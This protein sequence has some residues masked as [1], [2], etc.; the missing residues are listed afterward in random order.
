MT[1]T[2]DSFDSGKNATPSPS[3]KPAA[4]EVVRP[5]FHPN[6]RWVCGYQPVGMGCVEGPTEEG[7]CCQN[8]HQ[9]ASREASCDS[10]CGCAAH[11]ELAALRNNPGLPSHLELGP[12]VPRRS[13]WFTRQTIGLN[14]AILTGG[15]L[16]LCMA[17]PVREQVFVPGGLS[18]KHS[19]ILGN[20]LVSQRCSLCHAN[21]HSGGEVIAQD[22]LCMN[23]HQSHMPDAVLRSPHD[24]NAEQLSAIRW[25]PATQLVSTQSETSENPLEQTRCASCHKEH[26]GENHQLDF[27][28]DTRCQ[29]CHAQKFASLA[30][31]HPEFENFPQPARRSI[32]F[33][34]Q[35]HA[36]QHF[37]KKD[38][39]FDCRAC[40]LVSV[41][42]NSVGVVLR[43]QAFEVAC[44]SCHADRLKSAGVGGWAL[45]QVPSLEA[46]DVSDSANDFGNWP[47]G[48]QFGY[49]GTVPLV[50]RLLLSSDENAGEALAQL[51]TDGALG[52][53]DP[54]IQAEA[55]RALALATRALIA[56]VALHG[57]AA[58]RERLETVAT[59]KLGRQLDEDELRLVDQLSAGLPPDL[60][61]AMYR[62]WFAS[63]ANLAASG[64][65]PRTAAVSQVA[66]PAQLT[67]GLGGSPAD[68]LSAD[69]DL[70]LADDDALLEGDASN[71]ESRDGQAAPL[72]ELKGP[73]HV[74]GGGWYLDNE[75][76]VLRYMPSGHADTT[77]AAWAQFAN[78]LSS[79][80]VWDAS[81]RDPVLNSCLECHQLH[82][83]PSATWD[84]W[85]VAQPLA[86]VKQF[87]K[88]NHAPHL[89]LPAVNR[90]QYCHV[91]MDAPVAAD[92]ET[93]APARFVSARP[94]AENTRSL[95]AMELDEATVA[96]L[97]EVAQRLSG[98]SS[99]SG[100]AGWH[101]DFKPMQREQ[102]AACHRSGS[103][104]DRCT[105]CHNYHVGSSGFEALGK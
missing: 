77:L 103:A 7:I 24:L 25:Q 90:C 31:G 95:D 18:S 50:M 38:Q 54:A 16:L 57:Q 58:W 40:H 88:F 79:P 74:Q 59:A 1:K 70:L 61:R 55:S 17:L 22:D 63:A 56:D 42:S 10:N 105:N 20:R 26:H 29:A 8:V 104:S 15:L 23:C 82:G 64:R 27:M 53:L 68:E 13:A 100:H 41:G 30:N 89:T 6:A 44:A 47:E 85:K 102:C 84:D 93:S 35:A 11:C 36:N 60:F 86:G 67:S 9:P 2:E 51:P 65:G 101:G 91:L 75:L 43:T 48:A 87:T 49:D 76:Y 52:K 98:P 34:H 97:S 5:R 46:E 12:C 21:P 39:D 66:V 81:G 32:A 80:A 4:S 14:A 69:D 83:R 19:Q 71:S 99:E 3:P 37:S 62:N 33:D 73:S 78:L 72:A 28:S 92:L 94:G 96:A 45:L